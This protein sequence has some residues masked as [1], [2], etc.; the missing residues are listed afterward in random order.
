MVSVVAFSVSLVKN[1][2][3]RQIP[4]RQLEESAERNDAVRY[5]DGSAVRGQ[6]KMGI[7]YVNKRQIM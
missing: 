3:K 7:F 1:V 5:I 4:E 6:I 2:A